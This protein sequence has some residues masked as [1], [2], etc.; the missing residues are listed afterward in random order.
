MQY[1][2]SYLLF[3]TVNYVGDNMENNKNGGNQICQA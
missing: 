1:I 2:K 3:E